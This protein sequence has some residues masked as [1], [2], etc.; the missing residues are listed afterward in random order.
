MAK[1]KNVQKFQI[2]FC[3][4]PKNKYHDDQTNALPNGFISVVC[5]PIGF[6]VVSF[7]SNKYKKK[8]LDHLFMYILMF[9]QLV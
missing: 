2:P 9:T 5:N 8:P 1:G 6:C 7:L 3:K 4:I